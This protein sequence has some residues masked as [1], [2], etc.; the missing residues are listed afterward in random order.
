MS[1]ESS[2]GYRMEPYLKEKKVITTLGAQYT[3]QAGLE[4][5]KIYTPLPQ[6]LGLKV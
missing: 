2:M 1:F 4:L 6:K 3:D 5:T